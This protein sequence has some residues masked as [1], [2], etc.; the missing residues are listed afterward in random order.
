MNQMNHILFNALHTI[1]GFVF[2]LMTINW[3]FT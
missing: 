1:Q 2:I 3:Q